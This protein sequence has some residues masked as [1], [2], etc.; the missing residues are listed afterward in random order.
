MQ[1]E[2]LIYD[3]SGF[4]IGSAPTPQI[5]QSYLRYVQIAGE[6]KL[7]IFRGTIREL[8]RDRVSWLEREVEVRYYEL[9]EQF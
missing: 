7:D 3:E 2:D 5:P 6:A 4:V 9:K 8:E 1:S